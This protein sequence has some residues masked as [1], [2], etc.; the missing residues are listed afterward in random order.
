MERSMKLV[1]NNATTLWNKLFF[2]FPNIRN[3]TV[4]TGNER[5]LVVK[6]NESESH[7]C[8]TAG[9]CSVL[10]DSCNIWSIFGGAERPLRAGVLVGPARFA[11]SRLVELNAPG[12][13]SPNWK[14]FHVK[15][16]FCETVE[17]KI[18]WNIG[19]A[20]GFNVTFCSRWASLSVSHMFRQANMTITAERLSGVKGQRG[21]LGSPLTTWAV[22]KWVGLSVY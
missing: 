14:H 22:N 12:S 20:L 18:S 15:D 19:C 13:W 1:P 5:R 3:V 2:S 21:H 17:I 9:S 11:L 10:A 4:G 7:R 8:F 16:V 6:P